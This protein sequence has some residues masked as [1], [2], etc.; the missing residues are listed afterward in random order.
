MSPREVI[1]TYMILKNG[2]RGVFENVT[3]FF[4]LRIHYF[5]PENPDTFS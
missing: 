1:K 3:T 2:R 4:P 5:A